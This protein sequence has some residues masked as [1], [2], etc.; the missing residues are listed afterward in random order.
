[1]KVRIKNKD[2]SKISLIT[3]LGG[4]YAK[5]LGLVI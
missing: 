4:R 3:L 2:N 5:F 1:M